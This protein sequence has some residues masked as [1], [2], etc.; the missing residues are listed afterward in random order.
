MSTCRT[1]AIASS[2]VSQSAVSVAAVDSI[3]G[4]RV[5]VIDDGGLVSEEGRVMPGAREALRPQPTDGLRQPSSTPVEPASVVEGDGHVARRADVEFSRSFAHVVQDDLRGT[6]GGRS[7]AHIEQ[8]DDFLEGRVDSLRVCPVKCARKK[9]RGALLLPRSLVK[10]MQR[11][12][13][14]EDEFRVKVVSR[15]SSRLSPSIRTSE[16]DLEPVRIGEL[17]PIDEEGVTG[18]ECSAVEDSP[19]PL[20]ASSSPIGVLVVST[21]SCPASFPVSSPIGEVGTS[22]EEAGLLP[23]PCPATVEEETGLSSLLAPLG[24]ASETAVVHEAAGGAVGLLP[25]VV[26]DDAQ[27]VDEVNERHSGGE[28]DAPFAHDACPVAALSPPSGSSCPL[29]V[30]VGC[31]HVGRGDGGSV[32]EEVR[33]TSVARETLRSQ[34]TDGLRQSPSFPAVPESGVEGGAGMGGALRH[35]P[36]NRPSPSP[37]PADLDYSQQMPSPS[38]FDSSATPDHPV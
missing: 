20:L 11:A 29:G 30:S 3:D 1:L 17:P 12:T 25:D 19:G 15:R 22:I 18:G 31:D 34:P 28:P 6:C 5:S 36:R 24:S 21:Q 23:I 7:V 8:N 4:A 2:V 26:D 35:K 33:V 9:K 13:T 16:S 38:D 14:E 10:K 27:L 32:S 37:L